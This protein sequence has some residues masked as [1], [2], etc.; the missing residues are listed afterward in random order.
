MRPWGVDTSCAVSGGGAGCRVESQVQLLLRR[1]PW[2]APRVLWWP[3]L[4]R[5]T[6][7]HSSLSSLSL[8]STF[9]DKPCTGCTPP[10]ALKW[11][12]EEHKVSTQGCAA[13]LMKQV[14]GCR[15][16]WTLLQDPV[17]LLCTG[18]MTAMS[19]DWKIF[20]IFPFTNPWDV[21][22]YDAD[23]YW[24]QHVFNNSPCLC[25]SINA[26]RLLGLLAAERRY[27][28]VLSVFWTITQTECLCSLTYHDSKYL[29]NL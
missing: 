17:V 6:L 21:P 19:L 13:D 24:W 9:C 29:F 7:Q 11:A 23:I 5:C 3:L 4:L 27:L 18:L 12:A 15:E 26:F 10:A 25:V 28:F 1:P 2:G 22:V 16:L 14:N 8:S 20:P